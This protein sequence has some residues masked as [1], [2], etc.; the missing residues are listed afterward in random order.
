MS[1]QASTADWFAQNAPPQASTSQSGG[2]WFAQNAPAKQENNS[3]VPESHWLAATGDVLKGIASGWGAGAT[4][5]LATISRGLNKIP[6]IGET[7]APSAGVNA[8]RIIG[9]PRSTSERI[10]AGIEQAAELAATGPG[11]TLAAKIGIGALTGGA[12]TAVHEGGTTEGVNLADVLTSTAIGGVAPTVESGV[13]SIFNS[14]LARGLVNE[15]VMAAPSDVAY[16]NPARALLDERIATPKTGDLEKFKDAIRSGATLQGAAEAAG[17]RIA[18]IN[19][20]IG[21]LAPELHQKLAAAGA[22]RAAGATFSNLTRIPVSTVTDPID[23]GIQA[24]LKNRGVTAEDAQ[25]AI[26]ELQA[27][28]QA[29]LKVPSVPG[30]TTT[31]WAPVEAN[32]VKQEIGRSINWQGRERIGQLVEP[33]RR[34]VYGNLKNSVNAAAP[35]TAALNERLT[36]LLAAQADV[37][38]LAGFEEVG[39][40][41]SMGGV[42]GPSWMGRVEALAG[43]FVPAASWLTPAISPAIKSAIPAITQQNAGQRLSDLF[44]EQ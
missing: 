24:I 3:S 37:N 22:N 12:S 17:G 29:A 16:G 32:A 31:A 4:Q 28:K 25:A 44:E 9:T 34:E 19:Q 2:D 41:R 20:K 18:A 42:I 38:K 11:K 43:R 14:K 26:K 30:A 5:T 33:I 21:Q 36:N 1:G 7:L 27:L 8:M 15:S 13:K 10:G 40:G 39:R 23:S 6:G 35:G